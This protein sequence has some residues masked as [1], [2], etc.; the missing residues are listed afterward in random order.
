M[1]Y[2]REQK[3]ME[4]LHESEVAVIGDRL[5]TDVLMANRMGSYGIWIKDGIVPKDQKSFVSDSWPS[6][7]S[8][9]L[10]TRQSFA[11]LLSTN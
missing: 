7:T 10:K 8:H 5:L 6:S 3:G 2:F 4:D 11:M 9:L 1:A